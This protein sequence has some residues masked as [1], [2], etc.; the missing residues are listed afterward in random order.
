M[1][2]EESLLYLGDFWPPRVSSGWLILTTDVAFKRRRLPCLTF[3]I[4]F[5]LTCTS[6]LLFHTKLRDV[7]LLELIYPHVLSVEGGLANGNASRGWLTQQREAEAGW[8]K[9]QLCTEAEKPLL[10]FPFS[11]GECL[12]YSHALLPTTISPLHDLH[13]PCDLMGLHSLPVLISQ[14]TYLY[15][16]EGKS[17][18]LKVSFQCG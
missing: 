11:T 1:H 6:H 14:S 18:L 17:L 13:P 15:L 4:L 7:S 3:A 8:Q 10:G 2:L 9:K 5:T 16:S 12:E